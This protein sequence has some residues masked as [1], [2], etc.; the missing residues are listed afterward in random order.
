MLR[1]QLVTDLSSPPSSALTMAAPS[2]EPRLQSWSTNLPAANGAGQEGDDLAPTQPE[3]AEAGVP[4][5]EEEVL[6]CDVDEKKIEKYFRRGFDKKEYYKIAKVKV[7][8][9]YNR[10][11][12]FMAMAKNRNMGPW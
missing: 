7:D 6:S 2:S 10:E 9:T 5:A 3:P 8:N 11:E 12:A 4:G 1:A